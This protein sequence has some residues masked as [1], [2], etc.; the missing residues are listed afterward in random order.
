MAPHLGFSGSA[1][2]LS[3]TN[4]W[5]AEPRLVVPASCALRPAGACVS[6]PAHNSC[7]LCPRQ[8]VRPRNRDD[9]NGDD[10]HEGHRERKDVRMIG[11]IADYHLLRPPAEKRPRSSQPAGRRSTGPDYYTSAS[12]AHASHCFQL[13]SNSPFAASSVATRVE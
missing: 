3:A 4:A 1:T 11:R 5:K 2:G 8:H 12:F 6:S 10:Q 13:V 9:Q 7:L